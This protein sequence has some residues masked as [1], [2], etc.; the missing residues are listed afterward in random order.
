MFLAAIK[1]R[2]V[3][4]PTESAAERPCLFSKGRC[5]A[6]LREVAGA[7]SRTAMRLIEISVMSCQA[8]VRYDCQSAVLRNS[9]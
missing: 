6:L 8:L 2:T 7:F 4:D 5:S 9:R 1:S 3:R